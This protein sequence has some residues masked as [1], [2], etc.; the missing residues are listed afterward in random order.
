LP[1][2]IETYFLQPRLT[3]L[4]FSVF[5]WTVT[6]AI[7]YM[8]F[9]W[10]YRRLD[11]Y[12]PVARPLLVGAAWAA[13]E[14]LRGRLLTGSGFFV[15]NPWALVAYS[16]VG[17]DALV[18]VASVTG[19]YGISFLIAA[20]NAAWIERRLV[21]VV[22]PALLVAATLGYGV[23]SL[24]EAEA[25]PAAAVEI[26]VVQGNVAIGS[27]WRSDSYGRNLDLYLRLTART[28][29][30][31]PALV[32]WPESAL[33]FFLEDEPLYRR[34]IARMLS[35]RD[36]ELVVGGPRQLGDGLYRNGVFLMEPD[37]RITG[38]YDKRYLVPF[39][40]FF[41]LR[42]LD[43]L[44]RR[45]ERVRVF[46]PGE[47]SPPLSTRAGRA[48]V[49]ICNEA[50][51]P[52]A[53]GERVQEG[54]EILFVPSNDTWIEDP[55]WAA[56]MF[57]L[58]SLRAV[59]QRRY[60]VRASSSG[61]SAIVDPWG[62]VVARSEPMS[63]AVLVGRVAP[64]RERSVYGRIGDAFSGIA[65]AVVGVAALRARWPARA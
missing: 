49:L 29:D 33:T 38:R 59:E 19:V 27:V 61:P 45:F 65:L 25:E 51:L 22:A 26:A 9:A 16:Q 17:W 39:A 47:P 20:V 31:K 2:A 57:D 37:G 8:A 40:E 63:E 41:P 44:R 46:A 55:D 62:R 1:A 64:R 5:V 32:L 35:A 28:L 36:A 14:M 54:A 10:I 11:S 43:F 6:G 12:G 34:A 24:D 4:G 18:Q 52:E 56:R 30:A 21:A 42:S 23:W 53:A 48:G 15:G 7:Y 3:S 58:V 50:M 13:C 60:L